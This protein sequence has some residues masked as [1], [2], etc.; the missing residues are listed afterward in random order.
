MKIFSPEKTEYLR[1]LKQTI[2]DSCIDFETFKR[3]QICISYCGQDREIAN[4]LKVTLAISRLSVR[5]IERKRKKRIMVHPCTYF[6]SII[7]HNYGKILSDDDEFKSELKYAIKSRTSKIFIASLKSSNDPFIR[8]LMSSLNEISYQPIQLLDLRNLHR[9]LSKLA[10]KVTSIIMNDQIIFKSDQSIEKIMTKKEKLLSVYTSSS[11]SD[12]YLL[13]DISNKRHCPVINEETGELVRILSRGDVYEKIPPMLDAISPKVR[14]AANLKLNS[15]D[16]TKALM[17]FVNQTVGQVFRDDQKPVFLSDSSWGNKE[18]DTIHSAIQKFVTKDPVYFTALPVLNSENQIKGIV[19]FVDIFK[20]CLMGED[21]FLDMPLCEL[22]SMSDLYKPE[23]AQKDRVRMKDL[24]RLT[25]KSTF[26]QAKTI[27]KI[28]GYR[29]LPVV[30]EESGKHKLLGFVDDVQIKMFSHPDFFAGLLNLPVTYFMTSIKN[31]H[32]PQPD[33]TLRDTIEKFW[34]ADS[35]KIVSSSFA[36]CDLELGQK[37]P[38]NLVGILSYLDI[39]TK[40]NN[41]ILEEAVK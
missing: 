12:A 9:N 18:A 38:N 1:Y 15:D 25:S 29:S 19:S 10:N 28:T 7:P 14:S 40:W 2:F 5:L 13:M 8:T 22:A 39:L 6:I 36:I 23:E 11:V 33:D 20:S 3:T 27:M 35:E 26:S 32:I 16:A 41:K 30:E 21:D 31:L 24:A 17:K 37:E 4:Y 34:V